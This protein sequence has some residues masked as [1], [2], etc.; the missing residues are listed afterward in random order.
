[1]PYIFCSHEAL[2]GRARVVGT[3]MP[4]TR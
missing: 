3:D 4:V 1:M 2:A